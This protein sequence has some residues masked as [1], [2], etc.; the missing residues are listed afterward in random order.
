MD[1]RVY[2]L[3]GFVVAFVAMAGLSSWASA[4]EPAKA[5]EPPGEEVMRPTRMGLT[6]SAEWLE[7]VMR[8]VI[9][10]SGW[11]EGDTLSEDTKQRL[12]DSMTR[13][14][15]EISQAHGKAGREFIEYFIDTAI[16]HDGP[17]NFDAATGQEFARRFLPVAGPLREYFDA[18]VRDSR[19]F[20][21][22]EEAAEV[23]R[24]FTRLRRAIELTERRMERWAEG[25]VDEDG[26][27]FQAGDFEE[28]PESAEGQARRQQQRRLRHAR[29]RAERDLRDFLPESWPE[30][31]RNS[32]RA[33]E[34]DEEQKKRAEGLRLEYSAKAQAITTAEWRQKI[35]ANRMQSSALSE[36]GGRERFG[37]W[38]FRLD[39]EFKALIEPLNET[40]TAF[41]GAVIALATADQRRAAFENTRAAAARH[42]VTEKDL[43]TVEAVLMRS[44]TEL[45]RSDTERGMSVSHD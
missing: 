3:R 33:F 37:P 41:R 1:E 25:N 2:R 21:S 39:K 38:L 20:A 18:V 40:G 43:A 11:A 28:E 13:H 5:T 12:A 6:A 22:P 30:F 45:M 9:E 16:E 14:V 36:D 34:F 10:E 32:S 15:L 8:L 31:I 4:A 44:D 26:N 23:E 24:W 42:G 19:E 7:P 35:V 29:R 27:P 17:R